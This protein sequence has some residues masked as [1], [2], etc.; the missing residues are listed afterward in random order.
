NS[1]A[2]QR[3]TERSGPRLG[4][5]GPA[6]ASRRRRRS[7]PA[8]VVGTLALRCEWNARI[9][10]CPSNEGTAGAGSCRSAGGGCGRSVPL[11]GVLAQDAERHDLQRPPVGRAK[12]DPRRP[13]C[14]H[15]LEEARGADAPLVTGADAAEAELGP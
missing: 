14:L 5:G 9:S 15:G 2:I 4:S 10:P 1:C 12:A 8:A 3:P 7:R 11:D 6:E 13:A